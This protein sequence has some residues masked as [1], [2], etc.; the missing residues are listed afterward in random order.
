[1]TE[2]WN[3]SDITGQ[4]G[5][6]HIFVMN[7][8]LPPTNFQERLS[9]EGM[10]LRRKIPERDHVAFFPKSSVRDFLRSHDTREGGRGRERT[11]DCRRVQNELLTED[12][13]VTHF[14]SP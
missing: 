1:M 11:G 4:T 12:P 3:R 10:I 2:N 9:E 5:R 6:D 13:H 14:S 7:M 8:C